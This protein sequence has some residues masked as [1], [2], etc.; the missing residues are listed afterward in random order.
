[1]SE[2]SLLISPAIEPFAGGVIGLGLGYT[3]APRKY[4]LN[5]MLILQQ[6]K[7]SK[8]YTDS[9]VKQMNP[10][11]RKALDAIMKARDEYK[12]AKLSNGAEIK[13]AAQTWYSK[14][15]KVEVPENIMENFNKTRKSLQEAVK[16]EN[17]VT[18]NK[19]YREAKAALKKA[20][21]DE[22]LKKALTAA[23]EALAAAK[24]R[25][26]AKVEHYSN[27]VKNLYNERLYNIKSHPTKWIDVK[28]AYNKLLIALAK[29]RTFASN[30]LFE[31]TN[32]KSLIKSYNTIKDF[33]PK[34]RTKSA[35][36]G[37]LI[38]GGITTLLAARFSPSP[39]KA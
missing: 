13:Q 25:L 5:R 3:M 32:D 30:K 28:E 24:V 6:K 38:L 29:R 33:L 17:Y 2:N 8:I 27:A 21:E 31:L 15:K 11:E 39:A 20:P 14:F 19:Q 12:S 1:M 4:S 26:A 35:L 34:A 9:V 23:N 18:L 16:Q 37:G 36:T 7:L 22:A 10:K